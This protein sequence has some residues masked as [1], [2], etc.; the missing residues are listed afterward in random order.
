V[1]R[2][3]RLRTRA[4]FAR[5]RQRTVRAAA[6]RLLT[7]YV[8]PNDLARTR[9]GVAVSRRVGKAVVRNRVRRRLRELGRARYP[10]L[11]DGRDLVLVAQPPAARAS[12]RELAAAVDHVL[13]TAHLW[14]EPLP[15]SGH[16]PAD[17]DGE[18]RLAPAAAPALAPASALDASILL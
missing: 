5:A 13:T 12:W 10:R 7:L 4:D 6:H 11:V 18:P 2:D 1:D 16:D 14:R 17:P 8:A 15:G 9:L 3:Q